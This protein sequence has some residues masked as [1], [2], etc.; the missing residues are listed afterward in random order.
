MADRAEGF[1]TRA[2]RRRVDLGDARPLA[3][4]IYQTATYS[5]EDPEV[6]AELIRRGKDAGYVYTRWHNPTRAALE[7]VVADLEGG[8]RAVSF[9]SGMAAIA[10]VFLTLAKAGD[11]VVASPYLYGGSFSLL[12]KLLPRWGIEVT[13]ALSH[14]VEDLVAALRPETVLC[15]VET[16][17]NPVVPVADLEALGPVCR[18][19]GVKLVVDN[20]FASPYLCTPIAFGADVVVH[21]TTKYIGGHSD[22]T[23]GIAVG[24]VETMRDVR[25]VSVDLGGVAGPLDAWLALRG[26]QTLA[27]RMER[28]GATALALAGMLEEHD[29]VA[30]VWYPGLPSHPDHEVAQR[31]LRGY[32]GMLAFDL[33]G[34]IEAGR[35]FQEALEVAL[36]GASLG[37]THTLV[38]HAPSVTHTQLTA[39]DREAA[40]IPDG[41]VR[42]S[43]GIEDPDDLLDDFARALEKA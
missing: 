11:H 9:S 34:G 31:V 13:V 3:V 14:R 8:E 24:E 10:T 33:S 23:G 6:L 12:T 39:E 27:L 38:V 26:V 2:M 19:R 36:V 15:Y 25:E 28:H 7:E 18:E 29:K 5:Y 37:G 22:L 30:R 40:G 42:V 32:S 41:L 21:S 4:P 20:T 43:V 1:T 16:I 35:S 17:G